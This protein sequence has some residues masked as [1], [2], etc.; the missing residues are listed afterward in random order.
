[1]FALLADPHPNSQIINFPV[2]LVLL[3]LL[4]L[5]PNEH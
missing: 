5:L 2:L 4:E 1:M 3:V